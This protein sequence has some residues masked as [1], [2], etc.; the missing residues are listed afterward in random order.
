MYLPEG[1]ANCRAD[2]VAAVTCEEIKYEPYVLVFV[3][4]LFCASIAVALVRLI[5]VF[6]VSEIT[7][8]NTQYV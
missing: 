8:A 5:R 1:F 6:K 3:F 2:K 7:S 4:V